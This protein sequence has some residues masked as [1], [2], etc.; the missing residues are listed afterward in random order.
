MDEEIRALRQQGLTIDDDW[1]RRLGPAHFGHVNFR[2][3]FRFGVDQ[4]LEAL[5]DGGTADAK[6][7]SI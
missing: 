4:Y 3:T 1:L 6:L 2:G 5:V 7:R